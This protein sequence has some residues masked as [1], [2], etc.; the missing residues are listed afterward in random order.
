MQALQDFQQQTPM[1]SSTSVYKAGFFLSQI[2]NAIFAG[3]EV[4]DDNFLAQQTDGSW[5]SPFWIYPG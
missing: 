5:P 4:F 3:E 1:S 2:T